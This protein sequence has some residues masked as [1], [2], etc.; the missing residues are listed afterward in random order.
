[1]G[2]Y[3]SYSRKARASFKQTK[4]DQQSSR[5]RSATQLSDIFHGRK[6]KSQQG[7]NS[8]IFQ[9]QTQAFKNKRLEEARS[10]CAFIIVIVI[11]MN[12]GY[13]TDLGEANLLSEIA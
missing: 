9:R 3:F 12:M 10:W 4:S 1:V 8:R 2:R 7:S 6:R 13:A 5:G 11:I